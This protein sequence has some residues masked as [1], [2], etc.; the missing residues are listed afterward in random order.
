MQNITSQIK[1]L[2]SRL[3]FINLEQKRKDDLEKQRQ[4]THIVSGCLD[5]DSKDFD[6]IDDY[7]YK[8]GQLISVLSDLEQLKD[9]QKRMQYLLDNCSAERKTWRAYN[10]V[11]DSCRVA[12]QVDFAKRTTFD[13]Q[14]QTQTTQQTNKND[15]DYKISISFRMD[16]I[17]PELIDDSD[18]KDQISDLL[19]AL[20]DSFMC[21]KGSIGFVVYENI[22]GK[23]I[24][25]LSSQAYLLNTVHSITRLQPI[26]NVIDLRSNKNNQES[27]VINCDNFKIII[28]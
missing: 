26:P 10:W 18:F 22:K 1:S 12:T 23:K 21:T 27:S 5:F 17:I 6:D 13:D 7:R 2:Q 16:I 28:Q 19:Q 8:T 9:D 4:Y 15:M 20:V 24:N 11:N 3:D 25:V 14:Q